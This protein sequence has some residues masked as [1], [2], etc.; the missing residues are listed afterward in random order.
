MKNPEAE[1]Q[2]REEGLRIAQEWQTWCDSEEG[3]SSM[4]EITLGPP[5]CQSFY[6]KNRLWRAFMKGVEVGGG[7]K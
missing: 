4:N 1:K 5:G 7:I 6:L 3:K 2:K